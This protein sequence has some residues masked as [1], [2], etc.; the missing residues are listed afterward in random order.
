MQDDEHSKERVSYARPAGVPGTELMVAYASARVWRVLHDRYVLCGCRAA[1]AEWRYRGK[2][3]SLN[4]GNLM[5]MEPGEMHCNTTV[6]KPADFKVLMIDPEIFKSAAKEHGLS[7]TP[8]FGLNQVED[9]RLIGALY[10]FSAVVEAGGSVLEQQS[11]FA[12]CVSLFLRYAE[13][14]P[15]QLNTT[16]TQHAVQRAKK[17]LQER[18]CEPVGLEELSIAGGLSRFHLVRAFTR[19][20]GLPPH[21]YQIRMRI[22]RGCALLRAGVPVA[23]VATQLGFADQS[24]FTRHFKRVWGSTP[25]HYAQAA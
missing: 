16:N 6:Y 13:R 14:T 19:Y 7:S 17:Y 9:P 12:L 8:H 2:S 4:D 1:A 22:A 25:A 21:A 11:W 18:F 15:P 20:V 10:R 5:L 3:H 24:H 23:D